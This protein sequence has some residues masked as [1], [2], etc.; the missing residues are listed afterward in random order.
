MAS[1][2]SSFDRN[3]ETRKESHYNHWTRGLPRNQIQL[4]FRRHWLTMQRYLPDLPGR[5]VLEVGCGRGTI[6]SYF[7]EAGY[8]TTLLDSS[9]AVLA[10]ARNIYRA[11]GHPARFTAGDAFHLPFGD[12]HF[13]LCVSIGLLEHFDAIGLLMGEQLRVL[14]P[15]GLM[16]AYVVPER[17]DSVQRHFH[18]LNRILQ[19]LSKLKATRRSDPVRQSAKEPL[20]RNGLTA[21]SYLS[22]LKTLGIAETEA[23]GMYPLPMI[24]HSPAFP[25]SL[26]PSALERSLVAI[27][28][29]VLAVR[30]AIFRKDPWTCQERTG[31]AFLIVAR[32]PIA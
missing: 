17:P 3:W 25:F 7:A 16:L 23:Y 18:W 9:P 2:Q 4:A 24:S 1:V 22:A 10:I 27:F 8:R 19:S 21:A 30:R 12:N 13:S 6:S 28:S 14:Q 29:A 5:E 11:N 20:Y 31:Q 15:G 26:L 32:K